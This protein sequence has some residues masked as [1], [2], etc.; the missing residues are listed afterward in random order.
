MMERACAVL[1]SQD[2]S[3]GSVIAGRGR[4]GVTML[5]GLGLA[6]SKLTGISIRVQGWPPRQ[7][8]PVAGEGNC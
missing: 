5:L 1:A 6:V 7:R 4:G 2:G 3:G 8:Q